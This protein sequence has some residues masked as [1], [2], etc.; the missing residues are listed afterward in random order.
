MKKLFCLRIGTRGSRRDVDDFLNNLRNNLDIVYD[1]VHSEDEHDWILFFESDDLSIAEI[2]KIAQKSIGTFSYV[3]AF[4]V[5]SPNVLS[6]KL[7][8][9]KP[10][11]LDSKYGLLPRIDF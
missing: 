6:I 3:E 11:I 9:D 4:A 5:A 7:K 2:K 1:E 10:V 8:G